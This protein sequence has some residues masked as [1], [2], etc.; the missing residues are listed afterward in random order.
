[1]SFTI[2]KGSDDEIK[3]YCPVVTGDGLIGITIDVSAHSST[4]RTLLSPDL[5]I[6]A[7]TSSSDNAGIIEGSIEQAV[8]GKTMLKLVPKENSLKNGDL[9]VTT[10]TSGLFLRATQSEQLN[11]FHLILQVFH[12]V[13]LFNLLLKLTGSLP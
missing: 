11:Q 13:L 3:P 5:S 8:A 10:S 4:V 9:L 7:V 2:D 12:I 6:V 1:M